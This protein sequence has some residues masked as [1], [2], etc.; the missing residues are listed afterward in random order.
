[1]KK[2]KCIAL[3][4][5]IF[6]S[7][8]PLMGMDS[9]DDSGDHGDE[10]FRSSL[11]EEQLTTICPFLYMEDGQGVA[12]KLKEP[13]LKTV[14]RQCAEYNNYPFSL[15]DDRVEENT[16]C[17]SRQGA[18]SLDQAPEPVLATILPI[19]QSSVTQIIL[20]DCPNVE[21]L[22]RLKDQL[23]GQPDGP[24]RKAYGF[25][26][27]G[28]A[29]VN[30]GNLRGL[31]NAWGGSPASCKHLDFAIRNLRDDAARKLVLTTILEI[32][33]L[34]ACSDLQTLSI[35]FMHLTNADLDL[36]TQTLV[37]KSRPLKRLI[38]SFNDLDDGVLGKDGLIDQLLKSTK[39]LSKFSI[40]DLKGNKFA[41]PGL[42]D[43]NL[44]LRT[45]CRYVQREGGDT[46]KLSF[47][48][49][50][51]SPKDLKGPKASDVL[52]ANASFDQPDDLPK[53][54]SFSDIQAIKDAFDGVGDP[55]AKVKR[56]WFLK[57][58]PYCNLADQ[59][60]VLRH[61]RHRSWT[62]I[63]LTDRALERHSDVELILR[64][65]LNS[66][67][68]RNL[69]LAGAFRERVDMEVVSHQTVLRTLRRFNALTVLSLAQNRLGLI[70]GTYQDIIED[71]STLQ[72]IDYSHN[73][74]GQAGGETRSF[75]EGLELGLDQ[76]RE[77]RALNL[78]HNI[79]SDDNFS[80]LLVA[81]GRS[82]QLAICDLSWNQIKFEE[83][84]QNV[85]INRLINLLSANPPTL[86]HIDLTQNPIAPETVE[87][88]IAA[89]REKM[90][91][92]PQH[93]WPILSINARMGDGTYTPVQEIGH[94][95]VLLKLAKV[96]DQQ[97]EAYIQEWSNIVPKDTIRAL[98]YFNKAISK[99]QAGE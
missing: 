76:Q 52:N 73:Q 97:E 11:S 47:C 40:L 88:I 16:V 64:H 79:F 17:F 8:I 42:W 32:L 90:A 25:H 82:P 26:L 74:I 21:K 36:L 98:R 70:A 18:S 41:N 4:A 1:M 28:D 61:G 34:A 24:H 86:L 3:L 92:N 77:I 15:P 81:I 46:P 50:G 65:V 48:F 80:D 9:D 99:K 39:N 75:L 56:V 71:L 51:L 2:V 20:Q 49:S 38:L 60:L 91:T 37:K 43:I 85:F 44:G 87:R 5:A 19:I 22:I 33:D 53:P 57:N 58:S 55:P 93:L 27:F 72:A 35:R 67:A 10:G 83:G 29:N 68:L 30:L 69:K 31:L 6:L 63:D 23:P 89:Y 96:Y 59:M 7:S 13:D 84:L 66:A 14:Y 45:R 94:A 78:S 54:F 12:L 62:T 95:R